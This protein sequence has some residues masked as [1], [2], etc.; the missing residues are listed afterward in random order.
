M[1]NWLE[2]S[3][4]IKVSS[5]ES[6]PAPFSSNFFVTSRNQAVHALSESCVAQV[7]HLNCMGFKNTR[8]HILIQHLNRSETFRKG[9]CFKRAFGTQHRSAGQAVVAPERP[10]HAAFLPVRVSL[11]RPGQASKLPLISSTHSQMPE[12]SV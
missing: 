12:S 9:S 5:N 3:V 1:Y 2:S 6:L 11:M 8:A 4:G 7:W 10:R